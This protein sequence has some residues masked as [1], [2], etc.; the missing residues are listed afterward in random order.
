MLF[1]SS[2]KV[3][4]REVWTRGRPAIDQDVVHIA[5]PGQSVLEPGVGVSAET[6]RRIACD[7]SVEM[8][9]DEAGN[10]L[11][12]GRKRRTMPPAIR[13]AL[14]ARYPA[15]RLGLGGRRAAPEPGT[16]S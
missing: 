13:R 15:H 5:A 4:S 9:H 12:V 1:D 2:R 10:V 16:V 14:D 8:K 11:D 7:A 3:P 6:S